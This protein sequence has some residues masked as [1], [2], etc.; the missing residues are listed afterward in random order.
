MLACDHFVAHVGS[1]DLRVTLRSAKP[2]TLESAINLASE[3]ELIRSL[4]HSH[5]AP[6]AKV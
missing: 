2:S 4:E 3:L 5:L 6:D 1:G